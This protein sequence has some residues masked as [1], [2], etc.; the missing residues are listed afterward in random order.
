MSPDRL[1]SGKA[2]N[3][4]RQACLLLLLLLNRAVGSYKRCIF[5]TVVPAGS[6]SCGED[7]TVY[8]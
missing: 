3:G 2:L 5:S 1:A 8:L 6:P 7:V 4:G